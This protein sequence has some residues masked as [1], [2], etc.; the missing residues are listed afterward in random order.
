VAAPGPA[1]GAK[2]ALFEFF[3]GS[4]NAALAGLRL[5]RVLDPADE[6]VA[7]ERSGVV[8]PCIERRG[9]GQERLTQVVG[10]L[11]DYVRLSTTYQTRMA[12]C[13]EALPGVR[14]RG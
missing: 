2:F 6:L 12:D 13:Q 4:A 7:A 8:R 11:V 5:F 3:L 1:A 9:V 14:S 10:E